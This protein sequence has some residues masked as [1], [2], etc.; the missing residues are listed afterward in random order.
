MTVWIAQCLCPARH[1]IA[2]SYGEAGGQLQ[3]EREV[4]RPLCLAVALAL[5][6]GDINP[7]CG[8]CGATSATWQYELA[9]SRF[10]TMQE[11]EPEMRRMAAE[12]AITRAAYAIEP[13]ATRH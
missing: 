5:H 10:Q 8:L 3:A 1:A 6:A 4:R 9:R 13:N 2:A 7:W 11:A 12:Q